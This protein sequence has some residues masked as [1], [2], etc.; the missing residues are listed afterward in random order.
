MT[1]TVRVEAHC[2]DNHKVRIDVLDNNGTTQ[3]FIPDGAKHELVVYG[4]KSVHVRE[5]A[6][7]R[8]H[9]GEVVDFLFEVEQTVLSPFGDV[10]I[11]Q[12][13]GKDNGGKKYYVITAASTG[14][15]Y[16]EYQLSAVAV[17]M[18]TK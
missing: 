2:P 10:G 9:I 15:W 3:T 12:M 14:N 16:S 6:D 5:V 1:T 4:L 13:Q 11:V 18:E 17:N 8:A 7:E